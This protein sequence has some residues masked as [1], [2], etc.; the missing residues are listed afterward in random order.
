[1]QSIFDQLVDWLKEMLVS[2]IMTNMQG[3]FDSVNT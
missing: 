1:M 2:A 3:L